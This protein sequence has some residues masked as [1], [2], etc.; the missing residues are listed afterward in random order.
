MTLNA[1]SLPFFHHLS[2]F[3]RTIFS[4]MHHSSHFRRTIFSTGH[5]SSQ[6]KQPTFPPKYHKRN[7]QRLSF[8]SRT[9]PVTYNGRSF[10]SRHPHSHLKQQN[11][12]NLPSTP[13]DLNVR[14]FHLNITHRQPN[15]S[16]L[17]PLSC[18]KLVI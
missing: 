10:P 5:Q 6:L 9:I 12:S 3:K 17:S 18:L 13:F 7:L 14:N 2:R 11:F 4:T 1:R 8:S 16:V 15:Y